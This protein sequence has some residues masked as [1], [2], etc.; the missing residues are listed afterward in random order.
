MYAFSEM[1]CEA[2]SVRES[3]R[4][5][6][7][8]GERIL[9][10]LEEARSVNGEEGL[11]LLFQR[12]V[13]ELI[14]HRMAACGISASGKPWLQGR[15]NI[16]FSGSRLHHVLVSHLSSTKSRTNSWEDHH[17]VQIFNDLM[18]IKTEDPD[19]GKAMEHH[20]IRN[21]IVHGLSDIGSEHGSYFC[22][23]Q[24]PGPITE[25]QAYLMDLI[26]PHLHR[27]LLR[28]LDGKTNGCRS[29]HHLTIREQEILRAMCLGR[30]NK[31]IAGLLAI[32]SN[33][34]RN[35]VSRI[36]KKLKVANRT[37]AVMKARGLREW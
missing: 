30:T 27:A 10:L 29:K 2:K 21:M 6:W 36:C 31:E 37:M 13:K 23:A 5:G 1:E 14:P 12:R 28:T 34:V 20:G 32:S 19:L 33:T 8:V 7:P 18:L 4:P 9:A 16:G 24:C 15:V 3:R 26:T 17:D 25:E 11:R 35:H 22:L